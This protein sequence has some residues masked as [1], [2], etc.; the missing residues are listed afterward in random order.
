[1]KYSQ[2]D[3]D[4]VGF[5]TESYEKCNIRDGNIEAYYRE[6]EGG[7]S[8]SF[9]GTHKNPHSTSSLL[10][11][12]LTDIRFFPLWT[13]GFGFHPIGFTRAAIRIVDDIEGIIKKHGDEIAPLYISGHSLGAAVCLIVAALLARKK[14]N[15]VSVRAFAPPKVGRLKSLK[16]RDV[17]GYRYGNDIVPI[18]PPFF[19][20]DIK[21]KKIGGKLGPIKSHNLDNYAAEICG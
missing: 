8:F 2:I 14:Y 17:V 21:I 3:K 11:D 20:H 13:P 19:K 12:I 10:K 15:V 5:S 6:Y 18:V 16:G 1:M 4:L 7:L 9:R